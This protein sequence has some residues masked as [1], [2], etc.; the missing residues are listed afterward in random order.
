MIDVHSANNISVDGIS[1]HV[2][3]VRRVIHPPESSEGLGGDKEMEANAIPYQV[4]D[5]RRIIPSESGGE[6]DG[7]EEIVAEEDHE[8]M[9][10]EPIHVRP[11]RERQLPA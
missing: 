7:E 9:E 8:K 11:R 2:F 10:G 4:L 1:R 3:D 6:L 5:E